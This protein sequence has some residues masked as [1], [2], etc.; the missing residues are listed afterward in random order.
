MQLIELENEDCDALGWLAEKLV[1]RAY[2]T[3][4]LRHRNAIIRRIAES[5]EW[6]R[7]VDC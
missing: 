1:L 6:Q 2:F 7:Y 5:G 4:F 3:R